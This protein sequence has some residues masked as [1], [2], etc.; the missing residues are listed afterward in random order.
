M[1]HS[2]RPH[3]LR[4][5][6]IFFPG[7]QISLPQEILVVE[8]QFIEAGTGDIEQ[9]HLASGGCGS[10]AATLRNVLPA[11]S[12][13][14]NHLIACPRIPV[15]ETLAKRDSPI[16]DDGRGPERTKRTVAAMRPVNGMRLRYFEIF[17]MGLIRRTVPSDESILFSLSCF[18]IYTLT[19]P[20]SKSCI[21]PFFI[22]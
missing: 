7:R 2:Q 17:L 13:G 14:L 10:G 20:V 3:L 16:V 4:F 12:C 1:F 21:N 15:D 5:G 19:F 8:Q 22:S 6:R 9:F 18:F 11:A